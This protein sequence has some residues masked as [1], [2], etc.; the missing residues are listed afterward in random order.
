[1]FHSDSKKLCFSSF[2][3]RAGTGGDEAGL[4]AGDLVGTCFFFSF[5]IYAM[6]S[7]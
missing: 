5:R 1:M 3:V 6:D 2:A 7:Y 4:W